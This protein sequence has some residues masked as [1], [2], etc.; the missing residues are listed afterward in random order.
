MSSIKSASHWFLLFLIFSTQLKVLLAQTDYYGD[1]TGNAVKEDEGTY[2]QPDFNYYYDRGYYDP[3]NGGMY[4]PVSNP[5]NNPIYPTS[6][7]INN[8]IYSQIT[9]YYPY[10]IT[11]KPN[12]VLCQN[13]GGCECNGI[14][15]RVNCTCEVNGTRNRNPVN[16]F[17][18]VN[19]L[20]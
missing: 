5:I 3:R 19:V 14:N 1:Y 13:F 2:Q 10:A 17:L 9:P 11:N 15:D 6:N 18:Y 4:Q 8:P 20:Y 12:V 16:S 7:P